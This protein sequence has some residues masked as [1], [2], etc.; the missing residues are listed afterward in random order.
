MN[1]NCQDCILYQ[2]GECEGTLIGK[3]NQFIGNN[4]EEEFD[5]H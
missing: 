1:T 3:C 4:K 2:T 5:E